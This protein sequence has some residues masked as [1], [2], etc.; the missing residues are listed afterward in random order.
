MLQ[1]FMA[2]LEV[3]NFPDI[4]NYD[5]NRGKLI[6]TAA[7]AWSPRNAQVAGGKRV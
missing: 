6:K 5:K 2:R 7:G 4:I 1:W 3:E